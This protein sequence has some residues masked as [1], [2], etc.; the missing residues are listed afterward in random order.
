MAGRDD[1][2]SPDDAPPP[3]PP[4]PGSPSDAF[5]AR[6][7]ASPGRGRDLNTGSSERAIDLNPYT[8]PIDAVE[9]AVVAE[10]IDDEQP[11]RQEV[12]Q[13]HL[14]WALLLVVLLVVMQIAAVIGGTLVLAAARGGVVSESDL[15]AMSVQ[16]VPVATFSTV[17]TALLIAAVMFG[18]RLAR[19]LALRG[20]TPL[21]WILVLLLLVPQSI[22]AGEIANWAMEAIRLIDLPWLD[23]LNDMSWISD[24]S[25]QSWL[26]V[27]AAACL[28]PG[29]GEEIFFRG[30]L[31]RGLVA[32]HGVVLGAVL[33]SVLFGL[34]HMAPA[35]VAGTMVIGLVLQTVF[36]TTRSLPA[37]IALH[38]ANNAMAFVMVRH[39]ELLPIPG[40]TVETP[41]VV[42]HI[43]PV[44]V[45][46]AL[47]LTAIVLAL[48]YQTR[49][50]W[51]TPTGGYW[52]PGFFAT[53]IPPAELGARPSNDAPNPLL[54]V[55]VVLASLMLIAAVWL[56]VTTP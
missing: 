21:Q 2:H 18:H 34:I 3:D 9:A 38:T 46:A 6:V 7:E 41:D 48:F 12:P 31:S 13:P 11:H 27:F 26:L 16:L 22:L 25:Q 42:S 52:S 23:Q 30:I 56:S 45:A 32:R 44:M 33:A 20:C 49:T 4:E 39:S 50:R 54:M 37:V 17:V 36:M 24:F 51:V 43:P 1:L 53:E 19:K 15:Q 35:Q 28:F 40:Y 10:T 29:V 47:L 8:A 5:A 55:G 14:L